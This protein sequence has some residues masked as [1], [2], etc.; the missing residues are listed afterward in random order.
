MTHQ[1]T[2]ATDF[3]EADAREVYAE[4]FDFTV[5]ESSA[6]L[7][8]AAKTLRSAISRWLVTAV[9]ASVTGISTIPLGGMLSFGL[10]EI[11]VIRQDAPRAPDAVTMTALLRERAALAARVF[12]RT[13]HPGADD[14]EPDYDF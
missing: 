6:P 14:P 7:P 13:P 2:T 8:S 5:I 1:A 4:S 3:Y 10:S 12:E 9:V 11:S